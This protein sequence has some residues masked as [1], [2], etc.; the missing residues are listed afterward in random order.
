MLGPHFY[1]D[2]VL[3]AR[4]GRSTILRVLYILALFGGLLFAMENTPV[5]GGWT[6]NDFARVSERFAYALF[7]VQNIALIVL[8]PAYLGSAIAEEKERRTLE[9]LFATHLSDTQIVL[10]K[11]CA[12]VL[13]LFGFV[14][15]GLPILTV[16]QFWGGIDMVVVLGNLA[17]TLLN[18]MTI[19][20]FALM[21]SAHC[22]TVAGAVLASYAWV[23]PV[24]LF[25]AISLNGFPFV[26]SD[27]RFAGPR[28]ITVQ[29]LRYWVI[30]HLGVSAFCVWLAVISLR[31]GRTSAPPRAPNVDLPEAPKLPAQASLDVQLPTVTLPPMSDD[32]LLWKER[33][34]EGA[35]VVSPAL[36][37]ATLPF[38]LLGIVSLMTALA[39]SLDA[40]AAP[41]VLERLLEFW[42]ATVRF[43]YYVF[44]I[45]YTL[46]VGYRASGSVARE[47]Q[48][49]TLDPLLL[50]PIERAD[51]L[52]AKLVGILWRGWPW[53]AALAADVVLGVVLGVFHPF[54][55]VLLCAAPWPIILFVATLGLVL[56][57]S[58]LTVLRATLTMVVLEMA[59]LVFIAIGPAILGSHVFIDRFAFSFRDGQTIDGQG[60][61]IALWQIMG[62]AF[63]ALICW[64][65]AVTAFEK[66]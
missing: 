1:Y 48:Q 66:E 29:A 14:L 26:L 19:G 39:S 5:A 60:V 24:L 2:V 22:Q 59:M 28:V 10:G 18:V 13:H 11:L 38:F 46:G 12:R 15:A 41:G 23:L 62:F 34:Y 33:Y 25:F 63:G 8:T 65:L 49:Q 32:A 9:L 3:L 4:R 47:R 54:S 35:I 17:N 51:I 6:T 53:L 36:M 52:A 56:S 61:M 44:L 21:I 16:V 55:A 31:E 30:P 42:R 7:L 20:C 45:G 57:V 50:L 58:M 27:D 40:G 37:L 43:F 64:R